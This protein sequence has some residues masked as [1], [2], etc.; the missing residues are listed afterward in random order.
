MNLPNLGPGDYVV[1]IVS[2]VAL[3]AGLFF[4]GKNI[5]LWFIGVV[6]VLGSIA[7][8][9]QRLGIMSG[10]TLLLVTALV[11]IVLSFPLLRGSGAAGK[12]VGAL[13]ILAGV[14]VIFVATPGIRTLGL[15][16]TLGDIVAAGWN[17]IVRI[18][19]TANR[20]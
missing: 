13:G 15:S 10:G 1:L 14:I 3:A 11:L 19:N 2:A 8:A 17:A 18:F 9:N 16:G 12:I 20:G 5:A 6:L 7:V 4:T